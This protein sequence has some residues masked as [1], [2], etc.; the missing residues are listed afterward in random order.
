MSVLAAFE[1]DKEDRKG[2]ERA[3]NGKRQK[4]PATTEKNIVVE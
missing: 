2:C 1:R 3:R 4:L